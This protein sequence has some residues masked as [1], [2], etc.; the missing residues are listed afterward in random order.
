M[1]RR[2][3]FFRCERGHSLCGLPNDEALRKQWLTFI[4]NTIPEQYNSNIVLCSRHFTPDS[5]RNLESY[6]SGFSTRLLLKEGAVP[7]VPVVKSEDGEPQ[8]DVLAQDPFAI[9]INHIGCQTS[10]QNTASVSTQFIASQKTV[11]TQLSWGTLKEQ[12]VRSKATQTTVSS[13]SA[14]TKSTSSFPDFL[15]SSTPTRA[16][17]FRP[18]KRPR[19]ELEEEEEEVEVGDTNTELQAQP[20]EEPH[21]STYGP[22]S[23]D[24]TEKSKMSFESRPR[25]G[26]TKY[27]VFESCLRELFDT[28]P[29]CMTKCDVQRRRIGTYVAF[30]QL[31]RSCNYS[32]QWQS[33]PI[34]GSTPVGNLQL[35]AATYFTGA[36]FFQLAKICKA[37]QF[38]IFPYDTYRRHA[39]SFLEPAIVHKW[40]TD[41]QNLFQQ[42]QQKGKVAV[43]GDLQADSPGHSAKYGSYTLTHLESN[44]IMDLQ[45]V[46]SD[47]V[48][49]CYRIGREGLKRSLDLLK[50]K[51]LAV[52]YV[53]TDQHPQVQKLLKERNIK[54][55]YGVWHIEKSLSTTLERL[56]QSKDCEVLKKWLSS[57]KNHFYWSATSSTSGSEKVAKWKSLVNHIQNVHVHEDPIFPKCEHPDRVSKD[58]K[59]WFQPGSVALQRVEQILNN[60]RVLKDVRKLSHHDQSSLLKAFHNL[61]LRFLPENVIYSFMGLLCRLYLA[62]MHH[63]ENVN[64]EQAPAGQAV[65]EAVSS[66]T[67]EC[68][69][70]PVKTDTTYNY[71]NELMRL[72]FEE[73]LVD[74]APFV[75]ELKKIPLPKD[76][77]YRY[78]RGR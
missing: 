56:A 11:A 58:P 57:M 2:R 10:P 66:E 43:G 46:M 16:P 65:S 9:R 12:H 13:L 39:R 32:R 50:S 72:V 41:Q 26:D 51:G 53:V 42:L 44:T 29:I 8:P 40:K 6:K 7:T 64:H 3:C 1:S 60:K 59:K 24:V 77:P 54:Q 69:L 25:Y 52:E 37:M 31:C 49:G 22:G 63:N 33:Q 30:T 75:E 68:T 15:P 62:V 27:L 73:V 78:E 14:V 55:L 4:F 36:S 28:C 19:L 67:G 34:V 35:S 76:L 23:S 5:F 61:I 47:E 74:P 17:G 20:H 21:E 48:G 18:N 38:Q 71:L 45:L 70:K